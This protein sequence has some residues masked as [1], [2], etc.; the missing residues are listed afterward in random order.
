MIDLD[1]QRM[2]TLENELY[3]IIDWYPKVEGQPMIC[4]IQLDETQLK[5]QNRRIQLPSYLEVDREITDLPEFQSKAL[6]AKPDPTL[7]EEEKKQSSGDEK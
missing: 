7:V 6:A 3:M 5:D 2:C 4:I 1:Y